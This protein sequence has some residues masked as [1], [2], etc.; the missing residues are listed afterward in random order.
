[1]PVVSTVT[2]APD[3][4]VTTWPFVT[5]APPILAIERVSPSISKSLA[6][7]SIT[8]DAS[9]LGVVPKSGRASGASLT[10]LIVTFTVAE[11]KLGG[12]KLFDTVYV[13]VSVPLK[14]SFG[15]YIISPLATVLT[16][17]RSVVTS[18]LGL[19]SVNTDVVVRG[20][21]GLTAVNLMSSAV[22]PADADATVSSILSPA[23]IASTIASRTL[24]SLPVTS[25]V[26]AWPFI[27]T[28]IV[29]LTLNTPASLTVSTWATT[30][31]F[32][33]AGDPTD[34]IEAP[35]NAVRSLRVS[36]SKIEIPTG[37]SSSTVAASSPA[38]GTASAAS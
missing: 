18:G 7:A 29:S 35:S 3:V 32:P 1:M 13:K 33:F 20:C 27:V 12:S 9:S 34:A 6:R 30:A 38:I 21:P 11:L 14:F 25:Y 4:S 26:S 17:T 36:L 15:V 8:I 10:G 22:E 5:A 2:A 19:T 24:L 16:T 37:V 28:V 23:L 31:T